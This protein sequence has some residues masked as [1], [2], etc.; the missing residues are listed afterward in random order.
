MGMTLDKKLLIVPAVG[1]GITIGA[2]NANA[3]GPP[4][5]NLPFN[6]KGFLNPGG[7]VR[8][9]L[10]VRFYT[11]DGSQVAQT[12]TAHADTITAQ[13]DTVS[14]E[15]FYDAIIPTDNPA[16]PDKEGAVQ[17][18]TLYV[19]VKGPEGLTHMLVPANGGVM[20]HQPGQIQRWDLKTDPPVVLPVEMVSFNSY[21]KNNNVT[22][23]W[24][25]ASETNNFGYFVERSADGKKWEQ[26]GFVEGHGTTSSP[27][28]YTFEDL[29]RPAGKVW[30]RLQQVDFDGSMD[31]SPVLAVD[32]AV[33]EKFKLYQNYPNPFNPETTIK[34]EVS[35]RGRVKI[36]V[37]NATGQHVRSLMD[38]SQVEGQHTL[39][40]NGTG[41]DGNP[42]ASGTYFIK[43][44]APGGHVQTIK[45]T[46][47]R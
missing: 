16:T 14:A 15:G 46:L 5:V 41:K 42:L 37:Y 1:L 23:E 38:H 24:L 19:T 47:M 2:Y 20:T 45:T 6:A 13:G 43:M 4:P 40:W 8:D 29:S 3:Q 44:S 22:L 28:Q 27:Q 33:P 10:D 35:Q 34:Y 11:R 36:D 32:V 21:L 25:T 18:D 26:I 39:I 12:Q 7:P 17:G 9:S 31:Y 30:Y